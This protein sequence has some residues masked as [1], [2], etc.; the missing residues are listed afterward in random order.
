MPVAV[1]LNTFVFPQQIVADNGCAV[2]FGD[3]YKLNP[4]PAEV[5]LLDPWG[6][7]TTVK[8]PADVV[9]LLVSVNVEKVWPVIE[10]LLL[11]HW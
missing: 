3:E 9:K 6:V 1:T 2:I 7:T 5:T 4:I 11:Y 8:R 10:I